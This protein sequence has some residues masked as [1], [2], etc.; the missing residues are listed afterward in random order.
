[1]CRRPPS[2]RKKSEGGGTSVQ[3][4]SKALKIK[5]ENKVALRKVLRKQV[6]EFSESQETKYTK[7]SKQRN[8]IK[9]HSDAA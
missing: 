4:L 3:R 5:I 2:L 8:M 1:M 6:T 7:I 9:L